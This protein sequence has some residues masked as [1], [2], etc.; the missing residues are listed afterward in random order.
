MKRLAGMLLLATVLCLPGFAQAMSQTAFDDKAIPMLSKQAQASKLLALCE[1]A[2]NESPDKEFEAYIRVIKSHAH[3]LKKDYAKAEEEAQKAIDS[4]KQPELAYTAMMDVHFARGEY[5]EGLKICLESTKSLGDK[6]RAAAEQ[7]CKTAFAPKKGAKPSAKKEQAVAPSQDNTQKTQSKPHM[8]EQDN[9]Q[10]VQS[11]PHM[12]EADSKAEAPKESAK[13]KPEPK[14]EPKSEQ[15]KPKKADADMSYSLSGTGSS[16]AK[17]TKASEKT[18]AKAEKADSQAA[19]PA[20]TE[21]AAPESAKAE[22]AKTESAKDV[23]APKDSNAASGEPQQKEKDKAETTDA[24]SGST[25]PDDS[26]KDDGT[27]E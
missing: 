3:L 16:A 24:T 17:S 25:T 18:P 20:S 23:A 21:A 27:S 26:K 11:K 9:S 19:K 6:Q 1:K 10:K 8:P 5:D 22:S 14:A 7:D 13:P 12:P 4:G 15:A 2:L